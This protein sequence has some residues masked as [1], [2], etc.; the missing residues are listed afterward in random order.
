MYEITNAG[1]KTQLSQNH[2]LYSIAQ[3]AHISNIISQ[4]NTEST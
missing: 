3:H 2:A 1:E 4:P